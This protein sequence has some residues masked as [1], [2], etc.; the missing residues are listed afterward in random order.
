MTMKRLFYMAMAA[1]AVLSSCSSND[2]LMRDGGKPSD[3]ATTFT[4][5]IERDGATTR[6]TIN[7]T[8]GSDYGKVLW[9]KG[10]AISV[11][12]VEY[13]TTSTTNIATFTTTGTPASAVEGKYKAYYPASMYNEGLPATYTYAAG[14][15]NMPMYAESPNTKLSFQHLCGVLAITVPTGTFS[16]EGTT[17]K[18]FEVSSNE[19]MHGAF[20]V[21][22]SSAVPTVTFADKTLSEADKK[23]TINCGS[24][25]VAQG[26]TFYVP[27]PAKTYY[28]VT[29]KISDGTNTKIM[30]TTKQNGVAVARNS[31]YEIAFNEN[32]K[33]IGNSDDINLLPG[34]FSVS[35]TKKVRFTRSN[36][37]W[38]GTDWGFEA[39]QMDY[40]TAWNA[41]HVSHFYWTKTAAASYALKYDES[42][43]TTSD[44][45]FFAESKGGL[46]VEGTSGL[47]VLS[48]NGTTEGWRYLLEKRTNA[49]NLCKNNVTVAG[50]SV[51]YIIAPDD[52][53]GTIATS[54]TA[55]EWVTA[56]ASGLVCLPP[57]GG[58]GEDAV[59]YGSGA[60]GGNYWSSTPA[61]GS[62]VTYALR[63]TFIATSGSTGSSSL[64]NYGYSLRLVK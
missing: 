11:N 10:D 59:G 17:I 2:E 36:L 20:T 16:G 30:R 5:I 55:D 25:G 48:V 58:R 44:V 34:E 37:Y 12:G 26:S 53:T 8:S 3:G 64:R 46:I 54:Y 52:Y 27:V 60:V 13:T 42:T 39:N 35:A 6:T 47:Y 50:K 49:I 32:Y 33:K 62:K 15:F 7:T 31:I 45:P 41:N 29:I 24:S 57:A 21:T 9:S 43:T 23:I 56:E 51:C 28:P 14:K 40:P 18:S 4:A 1:M 38:N 19:Q 63:H 22:M 61:S